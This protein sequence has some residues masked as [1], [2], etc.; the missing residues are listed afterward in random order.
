MFIE[1]RYSLCV[2]IRSYITRDKLVLGFRWV[3]ITT[4]GPVFFVFLSYGIIK[5]ILIKI[6]TLFKLTSLSLKWLIPGI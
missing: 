1:A 2:C 6:I 3:I 4:S 5:N